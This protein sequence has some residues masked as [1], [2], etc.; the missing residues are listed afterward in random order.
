MFLL[1]EKNIHLTNLSFHCQTKIFKFFTEVVL[2]STAAG[3]DANSKRLAPGHRG[4]SRIQEGGG[5]FNLVPNSAT[6]GA[7]NDF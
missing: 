6:G 3:L 1:E 2:L 7:T 5:G 4:G